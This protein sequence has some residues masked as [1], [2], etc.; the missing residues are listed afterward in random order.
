MEAVSIKHVYDHEVSRN[1]LV[2]PEHSL[3]VALARTGKRA[4]AKTIFFSWPNL[5]T[6]ARKLAA[7]LSH[8]YPDLSGDGYLLDKALLAACDAFEN[9]VE[10]ENFTRRMGLFLNAMLKVAADEVSAWNT[11]GILAKG[12]TLAW[13][14][15]ELSI[16][17]WIKRKSVN[18]IVFTTCGAQLTPEEREA[19]R[20][21]LSSSVATYMDLVHMKRA[22]G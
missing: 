3:R 17:E 21:A 11:H 16:F 19:A 1:E 7:T 13:N 6:A 2:S 15:G 8:H 5:E 22:E 20:I 14:L 18:R 9:S 4:Y 12:D 10:T